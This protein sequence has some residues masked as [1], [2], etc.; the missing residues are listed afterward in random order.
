MST[1]FLVVVVVVLRTKPMAF[2]LRSFALP[3][4]STRQLFPISIPNP[5]IFL[6]PSYTEL[7]TGP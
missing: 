4:L 1:T 3:F 2:S 5:L 7:E 6:L